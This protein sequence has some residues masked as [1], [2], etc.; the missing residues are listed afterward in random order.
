MQAVQFLGDRQAIVHEKP[1]PIPQP[2]EV[3]VRMRAA[4]ICGSDLHGYRRPPAASPPSKWT[5]GHEPCGEVV[6]LGREVQTV[7]SGERVLVYHRMGC[8]RCL[9]CRTGNSNICQ[10]GMPSLGGSRD[11][12][13]AEYLA[14]PANRCYPIPDDMT[15]EDAVVISCQAGTAYAPLRRLGASGRDSIAVIGLGPVGLCVTLLG[16]AMG[17]R[18]VGLDPV[19]ERRDLALRLGIDTALDP[20][21]PDATG[22]LKELTSGGADGLVETSGRPEA[23]AKIVDYLRV[24]GEAAIVGLGSSQ[25][26][27]NPIAF[28]P[29]Q[30]TLFASNLYPEWMLPEIFAFVRRHNVPLSSMIT[31]RAPLA[32]APE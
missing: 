13:D 6:E 9:Q 24:T 3:L 4:A 14:V 30:L 28:F 15:W 5:P 11:G 1:D 18:R 26:S 32:E 7:Q 21:D 25:P 27:I 19:P 8:G 29:K 31:H 10:T 16:K 2:G 20:N 12:A 17:A 22:T 23:H